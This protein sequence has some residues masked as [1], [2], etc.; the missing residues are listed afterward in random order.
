MNFRQT[1]EE[2]KQKPSQFNY[3]VPKF[4]ALY[5]LKKDL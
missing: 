1:L 5:R 2:M 4:K 3:D